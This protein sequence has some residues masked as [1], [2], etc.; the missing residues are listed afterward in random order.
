M[1][2]WTRAHPWAVNWQR[3]VSGGGCDEFVGG[4]TKRTVRTKGNRL[5]A[6]AE[7]LLLNDFVRVT[8]VLGSGVGIGAI[9]THLGANNNSG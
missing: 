6:D 4:L 9:S 5:E 8:L 2:L 7:A 3:R 1:G